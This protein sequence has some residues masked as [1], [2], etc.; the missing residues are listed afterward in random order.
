[1]GWDLIIAADITRFVREKY[2]RSD[3]YVLHIRQ[4][5]GIYV[6]SSGHSL[7]YAQF[8]ITQQWS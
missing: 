1:M 4:S 6:Y 8:Q 3:R 7:S 5:P 2:V